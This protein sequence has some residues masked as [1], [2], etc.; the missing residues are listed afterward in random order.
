MAEILVFDKD[1]TDKH[2]KRADAKTAKR[3]NKAA[4]VR[5]SN[6][7]SFQRDG[8]TRLP[9]GGGRGMFPKVK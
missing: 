9:A 5:A 3:R 4:K 8:F 1:I 2:R 7:V 6:S